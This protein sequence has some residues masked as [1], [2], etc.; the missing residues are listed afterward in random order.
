MKIN[1]TGKDYRISD[2][3][4]ENIDKKFGKLGKYFQDDNINTNIKVSHFKDQIKLEATINGKGMIFR[5]EDIN[6]N[7]YDAIDV[8]L[9]KLNN[10]MSKFKGR[11][12]S[13]YKGNKALKFEFIPDEDEEE[14]IVI[15]RRK[16]FDLQPMDEEEAIL[17]MEM[18]AH[19]F[20]VYL[21]MNTNNVNVVY[22]RKN[23]EYGV[24]ETR[25]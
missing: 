22:K 25:R 10:Q 19:D 17:Q 3:L 21:D 20:F 16:T 14:D 4:A 13:R 2:R 7:A 5:A 11:L 23:R 12:E 15:A 1:I 24:I 8:V 6:D 9:D 18:L